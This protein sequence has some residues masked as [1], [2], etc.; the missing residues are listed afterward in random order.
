MGVGSVS[1]ILANQTCDA[2]SVCSSS[3]AATAADVVVVTVVIEPSLLTQSAR[4]SQRH[5]GV[6]SVAR[7]KVSGEV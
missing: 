4:E 7:K 6:S 5:K 3:M 1:D 2:L